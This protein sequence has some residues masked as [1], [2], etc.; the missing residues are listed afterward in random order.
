VTGE[1]G[2]SGPRRTVEVIVK[3]A[4]ETEHTRAIQE[5][6]TALGVTLEPLHPSTGDT[7]LAT[8]F[9]ARVDPDTA[10]ELTR[11]L[12]DLEGVEGAYAKPAGEPPRGGF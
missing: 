1:R 5:R 11:A 8:Y 6:A 9:T 7:E 12:A 10:H 4:R 3:V 2:A